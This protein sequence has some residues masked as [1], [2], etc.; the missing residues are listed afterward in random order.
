MSDN[1]SSWRTDLQLI[2]ILDETAGWVVR[3]ARGAVL[4]Q[5]A[6][7]RAAMTMALGHAGQTVLALTQAPDDHIIVFHEQMVRLIEASGG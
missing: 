6:S 7:L 5:A 1:G 3:G 2:G 4:G